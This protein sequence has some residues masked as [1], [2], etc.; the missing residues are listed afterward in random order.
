M[1]KIILALLIAAPAYADT[2]TFTWDPPTEDTAGHQL[3]ELTGY[4]FYVSSKAGEYTTPISTPATNTLELE[5]NKPGVYFA[6]VTAYNSAGESTPSNEI[7]F[8]VKAK[9]PAPPKN[10][11]FIQKL[12]R[13]LIDFLKYFA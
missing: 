11:T 4:K 7:Q 2:F 1:K 13:A 5:E 8:E 6:V 9:P 10:L 3:S 12:A